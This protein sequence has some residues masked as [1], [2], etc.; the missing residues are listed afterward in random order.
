MAKYLSKHKIEM[1][2]NV[3]GKYIDRNIGA[4][5]LITKANSCVFDGNLYLLERID[6]YIHEHNK[7]YKNNN[8]DIYNLIKYVQT[9]KVIQTEEVDTDDVYYV[10]ANCTNYAD[11]IND[12]I[13]K[14]GAKIA[15][16]FINDIYDKFARKLIHDYKRNKIQDIIETQ[17]M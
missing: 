12:I 13:N 1:L 6:K 9:Y 3:T 14:E 4:P 7:T 2:Y 8:R 15:I 10:K 17:D 5:D 16:M 11:I